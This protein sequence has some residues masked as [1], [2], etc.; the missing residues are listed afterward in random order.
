MCSS[1]EGVEIKC[2]GLAFGVLGVGAGAVMQPDG[3]WGLLAAV[4]EALMQS[5]DRQD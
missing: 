3:N 5:R 4:V 1:P 2:A